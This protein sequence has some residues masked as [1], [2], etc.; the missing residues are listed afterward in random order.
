[1]KPFEVF[2]SWRESI[3]EEAYSRISFKTAAV[4]IID[5]SNI[6][7]SLFEKSKT[8]GN[9][10]KIILENEYCLTKPKSIPIIPF[11]IGIKVPTLT[12]SKKAE[13][14]DKTVAK[15]KWTGWNPILRMISLD[16]IM[17]ESDLKCMALT[18]I[19]ENCY[20]LL[21]YSNYQIKNIPNKIC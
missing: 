21:L 12:A 18:S 6:N 19:Q 20:T 2:L 16:F 13:T 1:M 5:K 10:L 4:K 7:I 15:I 3:R 14:K 8:L 17:L 9:F 11:N